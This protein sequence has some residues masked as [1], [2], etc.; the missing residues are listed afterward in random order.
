VKDGGVKKFW[1]PLLLT[2]VTTACLAP[3]I[4]KAFHMDD[5][6]FMW[7]AKH[8]QSDPANFY[9]F[10]VNWDGIVRPMSD[11]TQNP[12]LAAY[13][14]ALIGSLFGW[15]ERVL[16]AAFLLPALAVVLGTYRLARNFCTHPGWAALMVAT[17]P[18]F[19][20][21]AT[22]VMCDVM[23]L[24]FWVWAVAFWLEGLH[25][26]HAKLLAAAVLI[27]LAGL[28]KY[29]GL[30]L[31]PLL[32]VFALLEKRRPGWWL[33]HLLLPLFPILFYQW[34]TNRLYGHDL[35]INAVTYA[36][37]FR[38]GGEWASKL[39]AGFAFVGGGIVVLA[40][41]T[42]QL[43]APGRILQV[44]VPA[45]VFIGVVIVLME[46]VGVFDVVE[47]GRV[48]WPYV[49]QMALLVGAGA[50]LFAM[51]YVEV[52]RRRSPTSIL[53]ALWIGGTFVFAC[54]INWTVSGRNILPMLP[55][56][57]L[58]VTSRL[59]T[60]GCFETPMRRR[61]LLVPI[62]VSTLLSLLVAQADYQLANSARTAAVVLSQ[63]LSPMASRVR[64]EGHWGFQYYF[65]PLGAT[66]LDRANPQLA[67]N[68]LLVVPTG[69]SYL[70][71]VPGTDIA[72]QY[73]PEAPKWLATM[74]GGAGAGFYSDG[75]GPMPFVFGPIPSQTYLVY[76]TVP[77]TKQE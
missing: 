35:L 71:D 7:C 69:N 21:S 58:L 72:L 52:V 73:E 16:H 74:N 54:V 26:S 59:E 28:T 55:A 77:D 9:G 68:Q 33:A 14:S 20:L 76:R 50:S 34:V 44:G 6:L 1:W 62:A 11:V 66:P 13:Y 56:V 18:V 12:P 27:A 42:W 22:N 30:S 65:E 51:V 45:L 24:G 49:L 10:K 23:M 29:F 25:G 67:A 37:E 19:V 17:A 2:L 41:A 4:G 57:A 32:L 36:T 61:W 43:W 46:K 31:V 8:I 53:L 47:T 3:F 5:P 70:F 38:V 75:W 60:A 40:A 48:K 39:L 15:S 64:F 63:K